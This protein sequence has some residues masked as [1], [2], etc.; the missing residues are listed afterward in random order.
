MEGGALP[1]TEKVATRRIASE[2]GKRK[3]ADVLVHLV[4]GSRVGR[5][6][7]GGGNDLRPIVVRGFGEYFFEEIRVAHVEKWRTEVAVKLIE[8]GHFAPTTCNGWISVLKVIAK[9]ATRRFELRRNPVEG[10]DPFDTS[11]HLTYA[12]EEPNSLTPDEVRRFLS[13]MRM[14]FP[15]HF[16]MTALAIVT[17]LRPSSLRPLRRSGPSADI[18]WDAKKLLVRRSHTRS[19]RVMERTKVKGLRQTIHLPDDL[20]EI[21]RWHVDTQLETPEQKESDLLF[22]SVDGTYRTPSVLNKPFALV[23]AE[24]GLEKKFT[25]RGCRRTF[26]DLARDAAV[27]GIVTRSISGHLTEEMQEHYST[28]APNEQREALA[29]V[30]DLA[31]VRRAKERA[32]AEEG[33]QGTGG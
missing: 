32:Q 30:F 31:G 21:L 13:E 3:W 19:E 15:Q 33:T 12:E 20:V 24:I 26:N 6:A 25:Q 23:A 22:P 28:V 5:A 17:G 4:E 9:A 7:R 14:M 10:V 1:S 16:A 29:R 18:K 11:E 8:P 2:V 27:A